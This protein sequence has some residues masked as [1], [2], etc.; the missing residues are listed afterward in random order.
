MIHIHSRGHRGIERLYLGDRN[1]SRASYPRSLIAFRK[2]R[3][4]RTTML[5]KDTRA[6][7]TMFRLP[8]GVIRDNTCTR[9][10]KPESTCVLDPEGS[11]SSVSSAQP[12]SPGF[13]TLMSHSADPMHSLSSMFDSVSNLFRRLHTVGFI[14]TLIQRIT[15]KINPTV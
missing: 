5:P 14:A 15:K 11:V 6:R 13:P 12:N 1:G 3:T 9:L 4:K 10:L 2:R 7:T 8:L